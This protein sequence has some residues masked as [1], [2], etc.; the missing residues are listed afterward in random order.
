MDL[1][2]LITFLDTNFTRKVKSTKN[3]TNIMAWEN[4]NHEDITVIVDE[5]STTYTNV[6]QLCLKNSNNTVYLYINHII[7]RNLTKIKLADITSICIE[8]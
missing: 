6:I 2:Q 3:D 8:E 7:R 4:H 1:I 5:T